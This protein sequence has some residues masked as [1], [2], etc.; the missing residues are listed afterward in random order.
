LNKLV[1]ASFANKIL[2]NLIDVC[3]IEFKYV[4]GIEE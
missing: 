2:L 4:K 1:D 3:L